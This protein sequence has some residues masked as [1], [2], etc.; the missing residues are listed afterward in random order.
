MNHFINDEKVKEF[1]ILDGQKF[2]ADEAYINIYKKAMDTILIIDD[3]INID[4]LSHLK[5]K[6]IEVKV[7]IVSDNKGTGSQRLRKKELDDFNLEY[8][9]VEIRENKISHDRFIVIDFNTEN[10]IVY[11]CGASS[12]DAGR[13][14]CAINRFSDISPIRNKFKQLIAHPILML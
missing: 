5:N 4:T 12:K 3:Y 9:F 1:I 7:I 6:K 14:L 2:E 10:E 11:H 8:P 13:K